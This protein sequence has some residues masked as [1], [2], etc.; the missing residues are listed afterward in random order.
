VARNSSKITPREMIV[1]DAYIAGSTR[2]AA[3]LAAGYSSKFTAQRA[4]KIFS[5]PCVAQY[6]AERMSKAIERSQVTADE[7]INRLARIAREDDFP[8]PPTRR[9]TLHA[10]DRLARILGMINDVPKDA[11]AVNVNIHIEEMRPQALERVARL[12][13]REDVVERIKARASLTGNSGVSDV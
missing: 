6:I 13:D 7:V 8:D 1:A 3:V 4:H 10:L 5:R 2:H 11:P 12:L 9:D